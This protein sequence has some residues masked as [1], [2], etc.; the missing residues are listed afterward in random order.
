MITVRNEEVFVTFFLT[1]RTF[2]AAR[3]M[4]GKTK[5]QLKFPSPSRD[6]KKR[7]KISENQN[8]TKSAIN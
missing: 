1:T 3:N 5:R 7:N 2:S 4:N 8:T 6:L